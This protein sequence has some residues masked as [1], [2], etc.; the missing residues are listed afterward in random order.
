MALIVWESAWKL[1]YK[2]MSHEYVVDEPANG[3][4]EKSNHHNID[5][6][7]SCLA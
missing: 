4:K 5:A 6:W 7:G 1:H 2:E 3:D